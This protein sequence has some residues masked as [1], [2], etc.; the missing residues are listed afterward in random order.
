MR[1]IGIAVI[2]C[3]CFTACSLYNV[4]K[5]EGSGIPILVK[6]P[7]RY[8]TTKVALTHWKVTYVLKVGGKEY[9]APSGGMDVVASDDVFNALDRIGGALSS[10]TAI[11]P[12]NFT[13]RVEAEIA[14][15]APTTTPTATATAHWGG[16][17]KDEPTGIVC[18]R[19]SV[20]YGRTI[21][22]DVVVVSELS[23]SRY[24]INT[25]RPWIGSANAT[26]D[27]APDGTMTKAQSSVEDKTVETLLSVLPITSFFTKQWN[28][29]GKDATA[30]TSVRNDPKAFA[31]SSPLRQPTG[32]VELK[33]EPVTWT[34]VLR[35]RLGENET[36][37][38]A[39]TYPET[40]CEKSGRSCVQ[41]VSATSSAA[42]KPTEAK[43]PAGWTIS[44]SLVPPEKE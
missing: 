15:A 4:T 11:T 19:P 36:V 6:Q 33:L 41:L 29:A 16:C 7:V 27:L 42:D 39:L 44:G 40:G 12:E 8:Q 37:A 14:T 18:V 35:R 17:R 43:K 24:Y 1:G 3:L 22:N 20:R 31:L 2:C 9:S 32:T 23:D 25:R 21:E 34:Y 26:I 10:H 5:E 30:A 13:S 38:D 28:L